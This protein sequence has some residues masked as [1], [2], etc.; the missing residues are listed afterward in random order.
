[1]AYHGAI[2]RA[3][4]FSQQPMSQSFLISFSPF[5]DLEA[6]EIAFEE[7]SIV[8]PDPWLLVLQRTATSGISDI[9][10]ERERTKCV[11][12]S[13]NISTVNDRRCWVKCNG[14]HWSES[15]RERSEQVRRSIGLTYVTE[16]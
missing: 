4:V 11:G 6:Q 7:L 15:D 14:T 3:K 10:F 16:R 9:T 5:A 8:Q 12:V 2:L 1:M 13:F